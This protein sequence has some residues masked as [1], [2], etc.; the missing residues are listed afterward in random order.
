METTETLTNIQL[1]QSPQWLQYLGAIGWRN[2]ETTFGVLVAYHQLLGAT[3]VKIQRP[4]AMTAENLKE[5]EAWVKPRRPLFIKIE[6]TQ[7]QDISVLENAGYV[8]S[9]LPLSP[10]SIQVLDLR[11]SEQDLWADVSHSAKYATNRA[12]R[13]KNTVEVFLNPSIPQLEAFH[14]VLL[15]TGKRGKFYIQ[16]LSDLLA[17]AQIFKDQVFLAEVRDA[18]GQLVSSKLYLGYQNTILYLHGGTT[19]IGRRGKGGYELMW[20]SM[21]YFKKLGYEF[22]DLDGVNDARFPNFTK[23]W[24]GFSHFKEKFG[25]HVIRYPLPYIKFTNPVLK[26]LSRYNTLPL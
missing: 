6:P 13:E 24:G 12:R 18:D 19:E 4:K 17:K 5:I 22:L 9:V 15:E 25:G 11:K 26:F 23:E 7:G 1:R 3:L 2:F 8:R 14:K 10:P 21:M 20:Q 16:P